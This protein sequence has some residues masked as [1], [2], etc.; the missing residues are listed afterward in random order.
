M[1]ET[2][3]SFAVAR[4]FH[5]PDLARDPVP[6]GRTARGRRG[7]AVAGER[8]GLGGGVGR[9]Q[10]RLVVRRGEPRPTDR[11]TFKSFSVILSILKAITPEIWRIE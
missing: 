4:G 11:L 6:S 10:P 8:G 1:A 3:A 5:P 2:H 7:S 9:G